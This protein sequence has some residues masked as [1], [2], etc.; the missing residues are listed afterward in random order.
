M[1]GYA[2]VFLAR[3]TP[4]GDHAL[5]G[6]QL[7]LHARHNDLRHEFSALR[8]DASLVVKLEKGP[9]T[10]HPADVLVHDH[11]HSLVVDFSVAHPLQLSA[12]SA[13]AHP[14]KLARPVEEQ[15]VSARL[16][17]CRRSGWSFCPFVMKA[18]GLRVAKLAI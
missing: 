6:S 17:L 14:G 8:N 15:K 18:T 2:P 4:V 1:R 3:W 5:R 13:E 10:L 11:S 7:Q 12:G 16:P 9:D